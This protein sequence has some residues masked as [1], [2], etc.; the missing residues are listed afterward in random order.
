MYVQLGED[1]ALWCQ[2]Q[3][4]SVP[5]MCRR[6]GCIRM[7]WRQCGRVVLL[8]HEEGICHDTSKNQEISRNSTSLCQPLF[9]LF[10]LY[11]IVWVL[12]KLMRDTCNKKRCDWLLWA[13][14]GSDWAGCLSGNR[15][16]STES[17]I[18]AAVA[19]WC[20]WLWRTDTLLLFHSAWSP[21][22][23]PGTWRKTSARIYARYVTTTN[24]VMA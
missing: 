16:P 20:G 9:P 3:R 2:C 19:L 1:R 10:A 12:W 18:S 11:T 8:R 23:N 21:A 5:Y 13:C 6:S 24:T 22:R 17:T 7:R 4:V 14:I 15:C